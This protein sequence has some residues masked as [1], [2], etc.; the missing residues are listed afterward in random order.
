META[1]DAPP[2]PPPGAKLQG[3]KF[4]EA[5]LFGRSFGRLQL[6]PLMGMCKPCGLCFPSLFGQAAQ[7]HYSGRGARGQ[8]VCHAKI[9]KERCFLLLSP[10]VQCKRS[11]CIALP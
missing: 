5:G 1:F 11:Q 6:G 9:D 3:V 4:R 2:P 10:V 7:G 8:D